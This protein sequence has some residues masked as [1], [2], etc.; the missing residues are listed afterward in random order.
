VWNN[1]KR[2]GA[3]GTDGTSKIKRAILGGDIQR[4]TKEE[5]KMR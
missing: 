5:K 3:P 4:N 1:E 2:E